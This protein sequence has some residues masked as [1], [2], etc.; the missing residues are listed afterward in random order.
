LASSTWPATEPDPTR[1]GARFAPAGISRRS[2]RP[3]RSA[4]EQAGGTVVYPRWAAAD[5]GKEELTTVIA[6][7]PVA[8]PSCHDGSLGDRGVTIRSLGARPPA[9]P[10]RQHRRRT[11]A[12]DLAHPVA[13]GIAPIAGSRAGA[14]VSRIP[15]LPT[16]SRA[17]SLALWFPMDAWP[18]ARN[19]REC[20]LRGSASRGRSPDR[21]RCSRRWQPGLLVLCM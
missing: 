2:S 12:R 21:S 17:T 13:A 10:V 14:K 4:S 16:Q 6:T 3:D 18:R 1:H 15:A 9:P 5:L 20:W 19:G 11:F 8:P 7:L